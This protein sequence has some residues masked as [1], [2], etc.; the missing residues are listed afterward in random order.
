MI[1]IIERKPNFFSPDFKRVIIRFLDLGNMRTNDLFR[2]VM[3]MD[4]KLAESILNQTLRE[5]SKR[6]RNLTKHFIRNYENARKFIDTKDVDI[7]RLSE[8]KK[9]LIGSFFSMEY[10]ITSTAF[11]NPS[12]V[13]APDQTGL[14]EG[15]KRIIVSFRATGE[16]HISS[17][18]FHRGVIDH[19]HNL[20]FEEPG[21]YIDEAEIIKQH[22]YNKAIFI[23]KLKEMNVDKNIISSTIEPLK[24][25]FNYNE[26]LVSIE[27][28]I[29]Q[30]NTNETNKRATREIIWLAD[31]HYKIKFSLDTHISE[32][33]IFPVSQA[34][35]KGIEDARFVKFIEDTKDSTYYATYT[36]FDGHTILSKLI[37][38]KDF[39]NFE[40]MPLHGEGAQNKNL[41]LFPRK[42]NGKY[43]MLSRID[44]IN[45]YIGFSKKITIWNEPIKLQEP[46]YPWEYVQIGNCGAPIETAEGWLVITHGVGPVRKYCIGASL[47]DL[48]D[49]TKEIGRLKEPLLVANEG[50]REGY[51]PNVVY[52]C[53]G[54]IHNDKLILP[55]GMS[56]TRSG[57]ACIDIKELLRRLLAG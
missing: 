48:N 13:E 5:F 44:G 39:Y 45:S 53:G 54:I 36:A 10:S 26:L 47:L 14:D 27:K 52:S 28:I 3:E 9:L 2:K 25:K 1:S 23:D 43:A 31:S 21:N 38:T 18:V 49:P 19:N 56:D 32:R 50:E 12:I 46:E 24:E 41:A 11:F 16:G 20:V 40:I 6:H 35:R 29:E 57:F 8:Q 15:S 33:V 30:N 42:I 17:I 51:V 37:Q 22:Y 4:N 55:Y 7:K 34:E